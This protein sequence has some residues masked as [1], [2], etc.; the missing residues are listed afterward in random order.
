VELAEPFAE[1]PAPSAAEPAAAEAQSSALP[2]DEPPPAAPA[3]DGKRE[4]VVKLETW[5]GKMRRDHGQRI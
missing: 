5:L 1:L 4:S 2:A 3:E